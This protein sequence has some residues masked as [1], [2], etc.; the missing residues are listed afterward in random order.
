MGREHEI[1]LIGYGELWTGL[2]FGP[3]SARS[4]T[5]FCVKLDLD[6]RVASRVEALRCTYGTDHVERQW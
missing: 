4:L 1:C 5:E 2:G 3:C 6:G